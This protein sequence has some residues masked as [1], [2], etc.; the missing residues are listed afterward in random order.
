MKN[1]FYLLISIFIISCDNSSDEN[2]PING[3]G[4]DRSQILT[5][6]YDNIIIPSYNEFESKLAD[7]QY[8]TTK[9]SNNVNQQNLNSLRLSWVKSYKTWQAIEMFDLRKAEEI[10]YSRISNSYPCK[11]LEI[12]SKINNSISV[13]GPFTSMD[14]GTT[15]FPAIGY[16]I[17][18][19]DSSNIITTFN[20]TDAAKH[21][22]YLNA[23]VK[24]LVDNTSLVTNDWNISRASFVNSINNTQTSSLNIIIN[25]FIY[26]LEKKIRTAKIGIPIDF[27]GAMQPQPDQVESYYKSNICK[28]LLIESM[29]SVKRFYKGISFDET[30][31]GS[32]LEDYLVYLGNADDLIMTINDQFIDI[33]QKISLLEDDFIL[34]LNNGTNRMEDVFLSIQNLVTYFKSDMMKDRFGISEDYAD[35]DGDGG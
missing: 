8:N 20:G 24:N 29:N 23:I 32:G 17:Y 2:E 22:D 14:L 15:G 34:E 33:E 30:N 28:P 19:N 21:I 6:T 18:G 25:D 26:F 10:S 27:F 7:L 1:L 16:M 9:F 3:D 35:N 4:F 5:N 12:Q 11:E 13:I 31:N